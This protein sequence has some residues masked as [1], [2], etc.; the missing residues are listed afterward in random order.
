MHVGGIADEQDEETSAVLTDEQAVCL[1]VEG[2]EQ[3]TAKHFDK[4]RTH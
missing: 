3:G 1:R 2:T 4:H